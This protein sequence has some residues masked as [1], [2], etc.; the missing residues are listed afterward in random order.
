MGIVGGGRGVALVAS[1]VWLCS[2]VVAVE[3]LLVLHL[4]RLGPI[5]TAIKLF[6][7]GIIV[8]YD[9]LLMM[10][11]LIGI[12]MI[13]NHIIVCGIAA[14]FAVFIAAPDIVAAHYHGHS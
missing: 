13:D 11:M 6:I 8:N 5:L 3:Q 1:F 12:F 10:V 9:E 2:V 4:S 14:I 7:T